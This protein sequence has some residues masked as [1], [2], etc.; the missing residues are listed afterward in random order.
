MTGRS[1]HTVANHSKN[2]RKFK[3]ANLSVIETKAIINTNF[4]EAK[5]FLPITNQNIDGQ[6][7]T[8]N[9][10]DLWKFLESG[11]DFSTWIKDRIKQYEFVEGVDFIRFPKIGESNSKALIEYHLSLDMAKEIAM[12]EKN[13]KSRQARRYSK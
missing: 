13:E 9:A 2:E 7:Q 6:I 1:L 5:K 11:K 3:L 10:R 8:V 12:V 4:E